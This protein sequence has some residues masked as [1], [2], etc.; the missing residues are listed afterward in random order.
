MAEN[1]KQVTL[2]TGEII[3]VSIEDVEIPLA[4]KKYYIPAYDIVHKPGDN[5]RH[6]MGLQFHEVI[7]TSE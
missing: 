1:T 3:N 4:G 2:C 7:E 6:T 5:I